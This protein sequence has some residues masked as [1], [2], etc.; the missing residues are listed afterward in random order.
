ML[1]VLSILSFLIFSAS[2]FA[3]GSVN[4]VSDDIYIFIHGGPGNQYRILGSIEAG[5]AVTKL[6]EVDGDYTHVVD[7][8][9]RKGWVE[10][11]SITNKVSF[12]ERL[13]KIE[14]ELK[15]AK[16]QLSEYSS[17]NTT[18]SEQLRNANAAVRELKAN[19][20]KVEQ[21]RD[22][23]QVQVK[24]AIDNQRYH[25]WQQG[26]M[27]GGLGALIGI[28][29]VYLPRPQRRRKDRW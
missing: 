11:A 24:A 12:R 1:R 22:T 19:L 25:M 18:M 23:A 2:S 7:P 27:I 13:P 21:E 29:L 3:Q 9:G 20:A 15:A 26:G 6:G 28:I 14:A 10:T 17:S 4:Y 5:Q 16:N 8:K